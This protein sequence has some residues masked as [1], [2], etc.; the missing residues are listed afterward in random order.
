MKHQEICHEFYH[1]KEGRTERNGHNVFYDRDVLYSYGHHFPMVR[2]IRNKKGE[3]VAYLIN[4]NSYSVTTSKHQGYA[5]S[6]CPND[7]P[8]FYVR[9]KFLDYRG[10]DAHKI[11][12]RDFID[13]AHSNIES[14][15]KR[16]KA[17]L[18]ERD[19]RTA[20]SYIA[21][22]QEYE[23]LFKVKLRLRKADKELIEALNNEG[24]LSELSA[25]LNQAASKVRQTALRKHEKDL[26]EWR[27]GIKQSINRLNGFDYLRIIVSEGEQK[28]QTS[29]GLTF[30]CKESKQF[31]N[32]IRL[33][34]VKSGTEFK[35]YYVNK[36]DENELRIGCHTLKIKE[37]LTIGAK[38]KC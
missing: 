24:K 17:E 7:A 38:L 25:K 15:T 8:I 31:Y 23:K 29:Q 36:I 9:T 34:K 3:L 11:I 5:M 26:I 20:R 28:I 27:N 19:V 22:I 33:K 37:C 13:S 21:N 18:F 1:Q 30:D 6:A 2:K 32:A 12:L 16:R 4:S 35:N 10:K 14:A